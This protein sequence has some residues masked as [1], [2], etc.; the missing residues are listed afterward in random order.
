MDSTYIPQKS[1]GM[2]RRYHRF[3]AWFS[4]IAL[5]S[6]LSLSSCRVLRGD[7]RKNCNHPEHGDYMREKQMQ[8][9]NKSGR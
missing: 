4:L 3:L 7:P 2:S 1:E 6:S 9:F 5:V 8:R